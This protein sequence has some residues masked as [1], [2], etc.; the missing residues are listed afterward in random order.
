MKWLHRGI[1]PNILRITH[2]YHSHTNPIKKIK[3][4]RT[5]LKAFYGSTI[6]LLTKPDKDTAKKKK[7]SLHANIS[8]EY[9]CKNP[10]P[11]FGKLYS[12][13]YKKDHTL[14]SS[15]VY[16]SDA[17]IVQYP[18]INVIYHS[19]IKKDKNHM[20][21]SID[22]EKEFEKIQPPYTIKTLF[23]LVVK[24]IYQHNQGHMQ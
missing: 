7:K 6:T 4:E 3:V 16:H 15:E 2:T 1:L 10:Q 18:K 5:Y 23:Q 20:I 24:G 8:E 19:N 11:N 9:K 13:I 17:S 14:W 12:A 22:T 21:I